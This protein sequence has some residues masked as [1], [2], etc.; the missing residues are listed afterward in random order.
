MAGVEPGGQFRPLEAGDPAS[1][2]AYRLAARLGS[3]GMGTV[4]LS[5]TPGG[6]PIALKTIRPELSEDP[7]FRRR[8]RQEVEAAQRVQGLYT[9]PV[10]DYDTEGDLPWLAT[11]YVAGPSLASAVGE[12]GPL[13]VPSVLLL[14][15]GMA[16][17][18]SVIHGAGIVHRDLKPSNVLLAGDGPRVIDFGIARAADATALTGTGVSIG[19]PAFMSPE[20]AAGAEIKPASDL[21]ALGQVAAFAARGQGAYGDGP[22]HAVLYRIVHEEPDLSGLPGQLGFIA[23]CLAKNPADRP[24]PA[25]IISL[26]QEASPT[27][28]RQSGSWLPAAITEQITQRVSASA[29]LAAAPTVAPQPSAPTAP[30]TRPD[31]PPAPATPPT[32][33]APPVH[34]V[35]TAPAAH[36]PPGPAYPPPAAQPQFRPAFGP[37]TAP[38]PPFGPQPGWRPQ[39]LPPPKKRSRWIGYTIAVVAGLVWIGGCASFIRGLDDSSD[40]S[41]SSG[42]SGSSRTAGDPSGGSSASAA[43]SVPDP[44]PVRYEGVN[45]P[46]GYYIQFQDSPPRPLDGDGRY[47]SDLFYYD[48]ELRSGNDKIVLLNNAQEGSL[49]TCREETRYAERVSLTQLSKGSELCVHS[50]SGHIALVTYQGTAPES[51]PS[52]YVSLDLTIWRNAEEPTDS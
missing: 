27:P 45:V 25:E 50:S 43:D 36:V 31:T 24:S 40:S 38:Q 11:A 29:A 13:P 47:Y 22:S 5:Y 35:P 39:P 19:T 1:V 37:P 21:F 41:A 52:D 3:G 9:A 49:K 48:G 16:E 6:H 14:L 17:A 20:Q 44:E 10:I 18:L 33:T 12:H 34:V 28:L 8:F 4:Y 46:T 51:D 26:C 30:V 7:Q 23:R 15:A 32:P 2:A 42:S